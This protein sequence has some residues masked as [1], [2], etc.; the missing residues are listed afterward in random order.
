MF[1][2]LNLKHK[3]CYAIALSIRYFFILPYGALFLLDIDDNVYDAGIN[4]ILHPLQQADRG[5]Y[6]QS[7]P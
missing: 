1:G 4:C 5:T 2:A 3:V 6:M 7:L